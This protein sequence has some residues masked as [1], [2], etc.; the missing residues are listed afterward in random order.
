MN[1]LR[2][3][4]RYEPTVEDAR[5]YLTKLYNGELPPLRGWNWVEAE[6]RAILREAEKSEMTD[7]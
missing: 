2:R 6:A 3:Q 5:R 1:W 7:G 4:P